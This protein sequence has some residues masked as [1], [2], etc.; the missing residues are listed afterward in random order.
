MEEIDSDYKGEIKIKKKS[1]EYLKIYIKN[2]TTHEKYKANFDFNYLEKISFFSCLNLEIICMTLNLQL[3]NKK[4][5]I[6]KEEKDINQIK[7]V[8]NLD[9]N[10][11]PLILI[12]PK[13]IKDE[14]LDK[15]EI[16]RLKTICSN[17]EFNNN[18]E[19]SK[20]LQNKQ[21]QIPNSIYENI[22]KQIQIILDKYIKK[23]N[24]L[25]EERQ[26]GID[27]LSQI[28]IS[29]KSQKNEII[30]TSVHNNI[31]C[32]QCF[33][34][35]IIGPR[36]KC[37]KCENYNLCEK[38]ETKN[39]NTQSHSHYFI[40]INN[41]EKVNDYENID[42]FDSINNELI[43]DKYFNL[44]I[45]EKKNKIIGKYSYELLEDNLNLYISNT[46]KSELIQ[47]TLKNNSKL[48]WPEN[49]T[50]LICN[51][52]ESIIFFDEVILPSLESGTQESIQIKLKIPED[53]PMEERYKVKMNFNVK[54]KNYGKPIIIH[55]NLITE[56]EAFKKK[57]NLD[58]VFSAQEILEALKRNKNW[59]DAFESLIK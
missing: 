31:K 46:T 37:S 10:N 4:V 5:K 57:F 23:F 59:E 13:Y 2:Y 43:S 14:Q 33:M 44:N 35:P 8:I 16:L 38:C 12:I 53:L 54:G 40:K 20:N 42:N 34:N 24:D 48:T 19:Y 47:L 11:L 3:K 30:C 6:L 41:E 39:E 22:Q 58:D 36:Y 56:V 49:E 1:K 50:K 7:L 25:K 29:D 52:K 17:F 45:S 27:K 18:G 28:R 9:K 26:F 21:L 15:E 32:D 55:V 51:D